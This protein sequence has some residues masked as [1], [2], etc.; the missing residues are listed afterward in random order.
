MAKRKRGGFGKFIGNLGGNPYDR[1]MSQF[2]R[3]VK[4]AGDDDDELADQLD[5]FARIVKRRYEEG[6]IDDEEHDLLIEEVEDTHP[7]G[8][9]FARLGDGSDEF[10]DSDDIP[11]APELKVGKD[12]DLDE[13][14]QGS[15][16]ESTG[17]WGAD[18]YDE[19]RQRMA[20]EFMRESDEA[21]AS[22]DH[23]M[24]QAQDPGGGRVFGDDEEEAEK[25]KR[26]IMIEEGM[27]S[28]EEATAEESGEDDGIEVDEDGVEWWED[29]DGQW[30]YR[31]PDEEDWFAYDE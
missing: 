7:D 8:K 31:P 23:Q 4:Q 28:E 29:E 11:D 21:I 12:V 17:S 26:K 2:E 13:L 9:T 6:E 1:L 19:Y 15:R 18:E 14:L 22:G 25:M 5:R 20:E 16:S 24:V 3:T 10:Y 30:W 27:I